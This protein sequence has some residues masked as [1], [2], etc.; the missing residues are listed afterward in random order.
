MDVTSGLI[1][2]HCKH[3]SGVTDLTFR[4]KIDPE[5]SC[6]PQEQRFF[7]SLTLQLFECNR[8]VWKIP[9]C[10]ASTI[11][12]HL[13]ICSWFRFCK[14]WLFG[15]FFLLQNGLHSSGFDQGVQ[16]TTSRQTQAFRFPCS[17]TSAI[18]VNAL[19]SSHLWTAMVWAAEEGGTAVMPK[20]DLMGIQGPLTRG[21]WS[22]T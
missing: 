9:N 11:T 4:R 14:E 13:Y 21:T 10:A 20:V 15:Q 17:A 5:L 1:H 2:D 22:L 3:L 19:L 18:S 6:H 7:P 8:T 12:C 16:R